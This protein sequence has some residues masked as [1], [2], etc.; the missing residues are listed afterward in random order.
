ML[1]EGTF[2]VYHFSNIKVIK[3]SQNKGDQGFSS[4]FCLLTEGSGSGAGPDPDPLSKLWIWMLIQET[5]K[6]TMQLWKS[7][8]LLNPTLEKEITNSRVSRNINLLQ[9]I[10]TVLV[11][12]LFLLGIYCPLG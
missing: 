6:Q 5:Q 8:S 11:S 4:F 10:T 12:S 1:F 2:T 9:K 3:K 7:P